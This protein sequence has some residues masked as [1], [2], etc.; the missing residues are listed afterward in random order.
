MV[1]GSH[2]IV[3]VHDDD[4]DDDEEDE[5]P[6]PHNSECCSLLVTRV[7]ELHSSKSAPE[8]AQH[9]LAKAPYPSPPPS[10]FKDNSLMFVALN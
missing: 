9:L 2:E 7:F 8:N 1:Q 5:A 6:A 4:D 3:A 10:A